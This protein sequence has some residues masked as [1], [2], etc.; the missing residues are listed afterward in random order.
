LED[1]KAKAKQKKE[2][3]DRKKG[4]VN[5]TGPDEDEDEEDGET[6]PNAAA[7]QEFRQLQNWQ[8]DAVLGELPASV[9]HREWEIYRY[10]LARGLLSRGGF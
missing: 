5:L 3:E 7:W 1:R 4:I 6:I 9:V 2:N 8:S 10:R